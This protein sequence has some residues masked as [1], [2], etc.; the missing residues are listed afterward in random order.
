MGL[1]VCGIMGIVNQETILLNTSIREN[2][3][4]GNEIVN[5]DKLID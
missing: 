2:I 3:I 1:F 4:Y 5:D